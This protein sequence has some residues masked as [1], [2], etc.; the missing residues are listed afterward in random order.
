[1]CSSLSF[2]WDPTVS[3]QFINLSVEVLNI[4][5]N[6]YF[7]MWLKNQF[8]KHVRARGSPYAFIANKNLFSFTAY[9]LQKPKKTPKTHH[10]QRKP[11]LA[12]DFPTLAYMQFY[13]KTSIMK[14]CI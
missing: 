10:H 14:W 13:G 4:V 11:Q 12:Q 9:A 5:S 6:T 8:Y 7:S 2:F 3:V 1:M